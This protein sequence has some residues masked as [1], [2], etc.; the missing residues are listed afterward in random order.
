FV[1]FG[2]IA[3]C[4]DSRIGR[5]TDVLMTGH[6]DIDARNSCTY[7]FFD[8]KMAIGTTDSDV[9]C[10]NL[11]C[12]IDAML[13]GGLHAQQMACRAVETGVIGRKRRRVPSPRQMRIERP[14]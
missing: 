1:T 11:M 2:M 3:Q 10:M 13:G 6:A 7:S 8:A 4:V 5:I 14:V 9:S 12:K